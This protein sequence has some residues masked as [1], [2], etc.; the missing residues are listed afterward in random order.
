MYLSVFRFPVGVAQKFQQLQKCNLENFNRVVLRKWVTRFWGQDESLVCRLN[1]NL[2]C[3]H[4][5]QGLGSYFRRGI[6]ETLLDTLALMTPN[7]G[8]GC[9]FKFLLYDWTGKGAFQC[10]FR[11]IFAL[12]NNNEDLVFNY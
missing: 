1:R 6:R 11:R 10:L 9:R 7:L 8:N 5:L 4:P 12:T 2:N 3:M